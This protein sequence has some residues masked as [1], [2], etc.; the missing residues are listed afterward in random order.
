MNISRRELF[1]L[2]A[3]AGLSLAAEDV[4]AKLNDLNPEKL[5]EFKPVGN[6]T[7]LHICDMHA[8]LK[9]L[10]WR[11]PS[12][13]ISAREL[14]GT[15]GFLCGKAFLKYYGI[16]SN[17]MRAYFDTYIGF[18]ELAKKY[19][20]MG[21]VAHIAT[22]VK[23]IKAERGNDKVLFM[24]SGDTWQGTA[25]GLFT[26]GLAVVEAQNALG[27]DI[28]VGHWEYT[29]GKDRVLELVNKHLKAEFISQN[30]ADDMWGDLIFKPY[31]IREVGGVKVAVIGNSFPYTPIAN[32]KEFTEGWT[33]GIQPERLQ[34]FVDEVRSKGADVVVLLS[35]DG[36]TLDQALAKMVKGIDVILSGHTHDPAPKPVIVNNTIIVI[37]GSHGK[38]LGRLDLEVKNK[39]ITNFAYKLYPVASNF[40]KPDKE[41]QDLVN[42]LYEPYEKQLSEVIGKT[43][44]ILYK[45]DTFY[46]TFDRVMMDAI[47]EE[48]DCEIVFNPGYRWG[49]TLLP[50]DNITVDDVYSMAAITYPDVYRF[51]LTGAQIK[52][53]LEDVADNVFNPNPLYQQ[54]GDMSRT[55]GLEYAIK[56]SAPTGQRISDIKVNGKDLD[57]NRTYVVASWGG[58]LYKMGK[59]AK[60]LRPSYDI[61][62]DYIKRVKV[63]NPPLKSNV[64]ILDF[65]C[66]CPTSEG[67]CL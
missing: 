27:L 52:N 29:Y 38:Y 59:N 11:E 28:M 15:P 2:A 44:T 48:A 40:I 45:R 33:F 37:A 21:G 55:L 39:K 7:L 26:K 6:V 30:V 46:S 18:E 58:N 22:L 17:T 1:H 13:L 25:I 51:E 10:Y 49:T 16:K 9:P 67:K 53:L 42:K 66:G 20:K 63:V 41:V 32:P 14:I 54:G 50:G 23:Q 3:I 43:E 65:D 24:D 4:F 19:G 62:I 35:H 60:K 57:P 12:T 64:K 31:T 56:I 36:F 61:T 8:H 47:K 5:F 34:K